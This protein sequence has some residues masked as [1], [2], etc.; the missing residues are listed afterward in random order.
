MQGYTTVPDDHRRIDYDPSRP[1]GM[2]HV[3]TTDGTQYDYTS[4]FNGGRPTVWRLADV[5][6]TSGNYVSYTYRYDQGAPGISSSV[7]AYLDSISYGDVRISFYWEDRPDTVTQAAPDP[8]AAQP[9]PN[10]A[11]PPG[12]VLAM[13]LR[14]KA[15]SVTANGHEVRAYGFCYEACQPTSPAATSLP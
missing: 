1:G 8:N 14:L 4:E 7:N 6:D 5:T 11:G 13:R 9:P 10:Y 12:V 3:W 15:I 2:W